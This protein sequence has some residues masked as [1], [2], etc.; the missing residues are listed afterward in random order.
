[1]GLHQSSYPLNLRDSQIILCRKLMCSEVLTAVT[2]RLSTRCEAVQSVGTD[3][4]AETGWN[5]CCESLAHISKAI[6][7]VLED[8]YIHTENQFTSCIMMYYQYRRISHF[9]THVRERA[10]HTE[11]NFP[12]AC[13]QIYIVT[14]LSTRNNSVKSTAFWDITPCC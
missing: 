4:S 14:Y 12:P 13:C 11:T 8:N 10:T 5:S 9:S 3:V 7:H 6:C 2:I 1:M